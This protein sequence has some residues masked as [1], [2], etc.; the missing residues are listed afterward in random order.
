MLHCNY[1]LVD[2]GL[3][4]KYMDVTL[5]PL[6]FCAGLALNVWALLLSFGMF[7]SWPLPLSMVLTS[8][9][10]LPPSQPSLSKLKSN[11]FAAV[12]RTEVS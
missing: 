12:P 2:C 7:T 3:T 6:L 8:L 4:L 10:C 11:L 9:P 5:D 1:L